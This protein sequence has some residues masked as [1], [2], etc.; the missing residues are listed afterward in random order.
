MR[1]KSLCIFPMAQQGSEKLPLLR[2]FGSK[3]V[4]TSRKKLCKAGV[5]TMAL[6]VVVVI[7]VA[8]AGSAT[9]FLFVHPLTSGGG[10]T[11]SNTSQST[12]QGTNGGQQSTTTSSSAG[13]S[14]FNNGDIILNANNLFGNF[15]SMSAEFTSS[16]GPLIGNYTVIGQNGPGLEVNFTTTSNGST[17]TSL[18]W[19]DPQGNVTQATFVESGQTITY[20]L[21]NG[22]GYLSSYKG[23]FIDVFGNFFTYGS[24]WTGIVSQATL[25]NT[26]NQN[27]GPTT[28]SV[29]TYTYNVPQA[30]ETISIHIGNV[31]NTSIYLVTYWSL[32]SGS[33]TDTFQLLTLT[34]A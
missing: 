19:F 23:V 12:T 1:E 29:T 13:S 31:P 17:Q 24:E 14:S 32:S 4:S 6:V 28:L 11:G 3:K 5:A 26:Q 9:Y 34:K 7:I 20:D 15:T 18:L 33:E 30:Q 22:S 8:A 16:S 21:N 10:A 2:S 25:G 27:F